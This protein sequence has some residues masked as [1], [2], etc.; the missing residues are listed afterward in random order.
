MYLQPR[1]NNPMTTPTI[2]V[3][4]STDAAAVMAAARNTI[5]QLDPA[6][7]AYNITT[8]DESL[9]Q[10]SA[11]S[12]FQG[13]LSLACAIV[14]LALAAVGLYGVLAQS[15]RSRWHELGIRLALGATARNVLAE[16]MRQGL[17]VA[18]VGV[19]LG[20]LGGYLTTQVLSS[21]LFGVQP[22]DTTTFVISSVVFMAVAALACYFPARH[23]TKVDPAVALRAE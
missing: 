19:L 13:L 11:M 6:L 2:I 8:L 1:D 17:A 14:A 5:R 10:F 7:A 12:R 20:L 16:V 9:A 18:S 3:S 21:L 22:R 23:A 15:V 4:A